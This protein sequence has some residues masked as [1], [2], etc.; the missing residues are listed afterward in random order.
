MSQQY[1]LWLCLRLRRPPIIN[2]TDLRCPEPPRFRRRPATGTTGSRARPPRSRRSASGGGGRAA[3]AICFFSRCR[4]CRPCPPLIS[5]VSRR[6]KGFW[7]S[8]SSAPVRLFL[9]QREIDAHRNLRFADPRVE[10][11]RGRLR[12]GLVRGGV[13]LVIRHRRAAIATSEEHTYGLPSLM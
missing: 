10:R 6:R 3:G 4:E 5:A 2:R 9:R 1:T 13:H 12:C 7:S 8:S 11:R